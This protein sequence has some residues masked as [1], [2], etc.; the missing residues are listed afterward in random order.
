M[1][2]PAGSS[3]V[4]RWPYNR[5]LVD[6]VTSMSHSLARESSLKSRVSDKVDT[7]VSGYRSTVLSISGGGLF[8]WLC[9]ISIS[10]TSVQLIVLS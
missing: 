4:W 2:T 10:A 8:Q 9:N 5:W 1:G 7:R 3:G 6:H